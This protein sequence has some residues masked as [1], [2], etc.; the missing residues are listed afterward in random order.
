MSDLCSDCGSNKH[1][2]C[3]REDDCQNCAAKDRLLAE[4]ATVIER[5][6]K[7]IGHLMANPMKRGTGETWYAILDECRADALEILAPVEPV[8]Q[9]SMC[10]RGEPCAA[11][12]TPTPVDPRARTKENSCAECLRLAQVDSNWTK[13]GHGEMWHASGL[14]GQNGTRC[15]MPAPVGRW[16]HCGHHDC[17]CEPAPVES[18]PKEGR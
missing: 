6:R 1:Y 5:A 3:K 11:N 4:Q 7:K 17:D 14:V 8:I 13:E 18:K 10:Q 15:S 12:H 16:D 9:C 2:T